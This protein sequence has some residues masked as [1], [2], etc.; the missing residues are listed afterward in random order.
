MQDINLSIHDFLDQVDYALSVRFRNKWK[1]RFSSSFIS[2]FQEVVLKAL[3]DQKP[4]KKSTLVSVYTKRLKYSMQT[5]E[6]FFDCI[7]IE[8]YNPLIFDDRKPV[9]KR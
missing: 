5:V 2:T 8:L 3:R 4:V 7:D 1:H 9:P 6:D